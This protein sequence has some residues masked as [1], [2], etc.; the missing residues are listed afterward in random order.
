MRHLNAHSD[1]AVR[2]FTLIKKIETFAPLLPDSVKEA[3]TDDNEL[4]CTLNNT[5]GIDN[6]PWGALNC[7]L[8]KL[9]GVDTR[10]D[11][12]LKHIRCG[13][14]GMSFVASPLAGLDWKSGNTLWTS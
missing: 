11:G 12:R 13:E 7:Q 3:S 6:S 9:F 5:S 2:F 14:H 8:D 1:L 4:H 10:E